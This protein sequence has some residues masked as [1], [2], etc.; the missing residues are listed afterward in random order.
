MTTSTYNIGELS[1]LA[2][3]KILKK[4]NKS[5]Y[6]SSTSS[7]SDFQDKNSKFPIHCK[8][9][10]EKFER[11]YFKNNDNFDN[12]ESINLSLQKNFERLCFC[13]RCRGLLIELSNKNVLFTLSSLKTETMSDYIDPLTLYFK[14]RKG[15]KKVS[16]SYIN[17]YEKK[18]K[19]MITFIAKLKNKYK[20][21]DDTYFLAITLLD[22]VSSKLIHF[23]VDI[24]LLTIGCFFLAGKIIFFI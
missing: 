6:S 11:F 13:S 10:F 16:L 22:N 1:N 14:M 20:V 4:Y 12:K 17:S 7:S 23:D 15:D 19:D 8:H 3:E 2:A 5:N 9:E 21:S 18:R 24:E